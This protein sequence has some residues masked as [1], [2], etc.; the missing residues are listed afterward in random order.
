MD[1]ITKNIVDKFICQLNNKDNKKK[2]NQ[3]ILNPIFKEFSNKIYPYV[4][5]LFLM[6]ILNLILVIIILTLIL[7]KNII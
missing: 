1:K 2:I 5:L 7:K 4:S 3:D 6:Y